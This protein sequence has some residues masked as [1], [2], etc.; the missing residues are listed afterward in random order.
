MKKGVL[1]IIAAMLTLSSFA[2]SSTD[3]YTVNKTDGT[4]EKFEI[5]DGMYNHIAFTA[6]K[7]TNYITA[8]GTDIVENATWNIADLS[9]VTFSIAGT[10]TQD[11]TTE[12]ATVCCKN[13]GPGYNLGN[14]FESNSLKTSYF[15]PDT[16]SVTAF[17]T[18]WGQPVTTQDLMTF[19][20][21][22]G[23][24]AVRLPVTW[25]QH[26]DADGNVDEAWMNRI[27]EVVDYIVNAGMYCILNTHHDNANGSGMA[28]GRRHGLS[29]QRGE[30]QETLDTDRHTFQGLWSSPRLRRLQ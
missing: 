1:L 30:V 18:L 16:A 15:D 9:N 12:T 25:A 29:E 26:M 20:H 22:N 4:S 13:M 7:M 28:Q 19:L 17:E 3:S 27:N 14:T 2:Q 11:S 21:N 8:D 24:G 23:F 10:P 5:G 6:D